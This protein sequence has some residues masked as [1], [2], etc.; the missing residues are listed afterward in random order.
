MFDNL[1]GSRFYQPATFFRQS[2]LAVA[3][4]AKELR[5]VCKAGESP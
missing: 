5:D 3:L 4:C 2:K 1:D